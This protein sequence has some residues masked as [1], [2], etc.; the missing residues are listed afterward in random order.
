MKEDIIFERIIHSLSLQ[1]FH[2]NPEDYNMSLV[3]GVN[4]P[5]SHKIKKGMKFAQYATAVA[6]YGCSDFKEM[7]DEE[8]FKSAFNTLCQ[9]VDITL[10]KFSIGQPLIIGVIKGDGLDHK[11]IQD[12]CDMFDK[13]LLHFRKYTARMNWTRLSVTGILMFVFFDTKQAENFCQYELIQCK[14]WRFWKKVWEVGW[15]VDVTN[16]RIVRHKG[17]PFFIPS[18][19]D[20]KKL[21][22]DLFHKEKE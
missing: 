7:I 2:V 15:I 18:I 12:I 22:Y 17:I 21:Q 20:I 11:R 8:G 10:Y 3:E 5:L 13:N 9:V 19:L 6:G 16:K 14:K 4:D 1:N